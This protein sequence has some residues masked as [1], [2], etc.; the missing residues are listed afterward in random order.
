MCNGLKIVE[1][2]D[3]RG[4]LA[5]NSVPAVAFLYRGLCLC[6]VGSFGVGVSSDVSDSVDH[7]VYQLIFIKNLGGF[8]VFR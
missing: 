1:A 2:A 6:P 5:Q 7:V 8:L 4:V 3:G